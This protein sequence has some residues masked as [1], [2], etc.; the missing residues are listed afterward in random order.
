[1]QSRARRAA[2]GTSSVSSACVEPNL[3]LNSLARKEA[4][5]SAANSGT[6]IKDALAPVSLPAHPRI[7]TPCLLLN[8]SCRSTLA[9]QA[10]EMARF[11]N[12]KQ[13][14]SVVEV[15]SLEVFGPELKL[16]LVVACHA[17]IHTTFTEVERHLSSR[18]EAQLDG[19]G[20]L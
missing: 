13:V 5:A 18:P 12:K 17:G 16:D 8:G 3:L 19:L 2:D 4:S 6:V 7:G 10:H 14:S 1:M 15:F 9:R 11:V 20:C